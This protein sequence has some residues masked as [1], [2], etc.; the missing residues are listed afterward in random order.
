MAF[1]TIAI[2][3]SA[4]TAALRYLMLRIR[5][6]PQLEADTFSGVRTLRDATG[7]NT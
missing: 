2:T 4:A 7:A 1:E 6:T 3:P 5:L